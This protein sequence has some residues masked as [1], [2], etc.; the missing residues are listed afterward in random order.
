MNL[1]NPAAIQQWDAGLEYQGDEV[2]PLPQNYLCQAPKMTH[3]QV[4]VPL[5]FTNSALRPAAATSVVDATSPS[6]PVRVSFIAGEKWKR[7]Y[8]QQSDRSTVQ[9]SNPGTESVG[10]SNYNALEVEASRQIRVPG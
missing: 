2:A 8:W 4:T 6:G 7:C 10:T 3:L 9:H 5:N 1:E